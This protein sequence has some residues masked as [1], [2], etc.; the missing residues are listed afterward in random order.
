M[1]KSCDLVHSKWCN[2]AETSTVASTPLTKLGSNSAEDF[3][4]LLSHNIVIA[5]T[6]IMHISYILTVNTYQ[7]IYVTHNIVNIY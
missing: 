2:D 4:L 1:C 6:N 5:A 7:L 3:F